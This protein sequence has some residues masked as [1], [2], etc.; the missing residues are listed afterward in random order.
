M[1]WIEAESRPDFRSGFF[2]F[3]GIRFFALV[4]SK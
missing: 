3:E 2:V 1:V 4:T